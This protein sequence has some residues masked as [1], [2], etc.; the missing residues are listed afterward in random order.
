[1]LK[2]CDLSPRTART[3]TSLE[4]FVEELEKTR[5]RGYALDDEEHEL[6]GRCIGA[7]IFDHLGK[8]V[9]A[10]SQSTPLARIPVEEVP[11][12]A[13]KVRDAAKAIS[14]RLGY[15]QKPY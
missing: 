4:A 11:V 13:E 5:D 15:V 8:P 9:A 12:V 3:I 7:P 10:V 6:G 14:L 2:E 1:M